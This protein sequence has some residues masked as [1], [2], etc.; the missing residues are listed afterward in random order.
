MSDKESGVIGRVISNSGVAQ[1]AR[2]YPLSL[3]VVYVAVVPA[4]LFA[5]VPQDRYWILAVVLGPFA[6][7]GVVAALIGRYSQPDSD[8]DE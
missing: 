6:A 8:S 3:A 1:A 7:A 2:N 5:D 4:V